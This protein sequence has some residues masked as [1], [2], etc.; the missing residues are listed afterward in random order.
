MVDRQSRHKIK[1]LRTNGGGEYVLTD[2][3]ALCER[4]RIVHEVVL[5]YTPQQNDTTKRKNITI[6]NMVRSILKG[7]YLPNKLWGEVVSSATNILNKCPTNKLEGITP[8]ECLASFR[9]NLYICDLP[10]ER[11]YEFDEGE[12][13]MYVSA[14]QVRGSVKEWALVFV[15]LASLEAKDKGVVR[16]LHAV[17]EFLE[18]F[19]EDISDLPPER[20]IGFTIDLVPDTSP[21]SMAPY[22]MSASKLSE[23]KK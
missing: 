3:N 8:E 6:M 10:L 5:T 4:E 17:C 16:D 18:V 19:P 11:E 15:I 2:F 20:E 23:L 7:K 12:E 21:V 13:L 1:T 14:K 9:P 22:G